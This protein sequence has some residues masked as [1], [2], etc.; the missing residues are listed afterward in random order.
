MCSTPATPW[1][2]MAFA[3]FPNEY[4]PTFEQSDGIP[5]DDSMNGPYLEDAGRSITEAIRAGEF[6]EDSVL[7]NKWERMKSKLRATME[8][9]YPEQTDEEEILRGGPRI[10]KAFDQVLDE[11]G[12]PLRADPKYA[13]RMSESPRVQAEQGICRLIVFLA[14]GFHRQDIL[15]WMRDVLLRETTQA[16]SQYTPQNDY[17]SVGPVE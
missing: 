16:I 12:K 8:V 10:W 4:F 9:A 5:L 14:V 13:R 15:R 1:G 11:A 2:E 7:N 6:V 17:E 3:I